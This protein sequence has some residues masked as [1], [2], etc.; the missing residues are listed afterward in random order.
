M[1]KESIYLDWAATTPLRAEVAAEMEPYTQ[2]PQHGIGLQAN[3][4]SLHSAGRKAFSELEKY[5]ERTAGVLGAKRPNE[6]FFTS[7]ATESNNAALF[8]IVSAESKKRKQQ[9]AGAFT[10]HIVSTAIEHSS[11]L[12]PLKA[13][14]GFGCEITLIKPSKQGVIEVEQLEEACT[15]NTILFSIQYGNNEIG[16]IQEIPALAQYARSRNI[17]FHSDAVQV[18][19]KIPINLEESGVSA[20]SFSAH[21]L[22]GP[23]G[24]G[25]LYLKT[26]TPFD[27]YILGGGQEEG[28]RSGTTNLASVAGFARAAELACSEVSEQS[29][30]LINLRDLLYSALIQIEGCHATVL[31]EMGSKTSLPHV[32]HVCFEGIESETLILRLDS[33]GF[34]V[35]G[36][37]SCSS[38]SL[39]PSKILTALDVPASRIRGALRVSIGPDTTEEQI[40]QFTY[41]LQTC[42]K[43]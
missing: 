26:R 42:V 41:A 30:Y 18:L 43:S 31:P 34:S 22:G 39:R 36:G 19:G 14:K 15:E 11:I 10:P 37:S 2:S 24:S 4:T 16:V 3:T 28:R 25:V 6:I 38:S 7:G 21:K 35:S 20:A 8:G 13:L 9:N 32:I 27:P 33:L 23:K 1:G 29:E 12:A 17:T 5:R 40:Q